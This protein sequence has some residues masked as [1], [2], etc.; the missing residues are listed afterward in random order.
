MV[1]L[2]SLMVNG[3]CLN[4]KSQ[5]IHPSL[6]ILEYDK[7]AIFWITSLQNINSMFPPFINLFTISM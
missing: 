4:L 3:D 2:T 7:C 5:N 1:H 6:K